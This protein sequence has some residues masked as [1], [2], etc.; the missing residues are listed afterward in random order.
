MAC[1]KSS[2]NASRVRTSLA[3]PSSN[4]E[5]LRQLI[6]TKR[7]DPTARAATARPHTQLM[8]VIRQIQ[9]APV[10]NGPILLGDAQGRSEKGSLFKLLIFF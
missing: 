1:S 6:L 9:M 2:N 7:G 3:W 4:N 10:T 8:A 5:L